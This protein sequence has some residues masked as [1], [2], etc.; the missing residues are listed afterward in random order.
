MGDSEGSSYALFGCDTCQR[1][2]LAFVN[3]MVM[4]MDVYVARENHLLHMTIG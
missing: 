1:V 3:Y 4:L 2:S